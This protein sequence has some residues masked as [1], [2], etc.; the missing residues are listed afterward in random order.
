MKET[1]GHIALKRDE[2]IPVVADCD[3]VVIGG[4]DT[5]ADCIGTSLRH[6]CQG[7]V[8]FELLDRPPADRAENN[9]WPEWPRIYRVDYSHAE[10]SARFGEDPRRYHVLTKAFIDDGEG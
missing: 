6:G 8:N 7:L 4:G 1:Y 2:Q 9:P 5:G 10:T 3:V